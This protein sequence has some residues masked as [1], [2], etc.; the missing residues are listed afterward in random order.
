[1]RRGITASEAI[2]ERL[3]LIGSKDLDDLMDGLGRFV[4]EL[5]RR[6]SG[7]AGKYEVDIS[8]TRQLELG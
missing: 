1:M 2:L 8:F 4:L 7:R 5:N 6:T 3:N